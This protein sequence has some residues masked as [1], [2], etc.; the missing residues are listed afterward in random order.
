MTN[1]KKSTSLPVI[2]SLNGVSDEGWIKYGSKLQEAGAD[3]L[4]LNITYIPTS[5]ELSGAQIED[6]YVKTIK[7]L[8]QH[9]SIPLNVKMNSYFTNPANMAKRFVETG[10][11][12]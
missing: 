3:A 1:V 8:K 10:A 6:M 9:I 7:N 12:G 4:E 5:L 2:A 11:N